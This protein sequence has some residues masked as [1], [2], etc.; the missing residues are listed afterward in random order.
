MQ[1][2]IR[3]EI[4]FVIPFTTLKGYVDSYEQFCGVKKQND[5]V[6]NTPQPIAESISDRFSKIAK[7]N[8]GNYIKFP[9]QADFGKLGSYGKNDIGLFDF[10]NIFLPLSISDDLSK[11]PNVVWGGGIRIFPLIAV[12]III[13][14]IIA[15]T[16]IYHSN[17]KL[18]L[19]S[20]V[21]STKKEKTKQ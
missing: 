7:F 2:D 18:D 19:L 14:A 15:I 10:V 20:S 12:I 16:R 1:E 8:W 9:F 21:E 3:F 5:L 4:N 17:K 6:N 13:I 11:N